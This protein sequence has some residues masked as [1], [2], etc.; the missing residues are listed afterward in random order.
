MIHRMRLVC[1]PEESAGS[2][3]GCG[4][5]GLPLAA[6]SED[7]G[8]GGSCAGTAVAPAD[9]SCSFAGGV[10]GLSCAHSREP[11]ATKMKAKTAASILGLIHSFKVTPKLFFSTQKP[12]P[13]TIPPTVASVWILARAFR[14]LWLTHFLSSLPCGFAPLATPFP[15]TPPLYGPTIGPSKEGYGPTR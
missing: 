6:S 3:L 13:S 12:Q 5:S 14:M 1:W 8:A 7:F 4:A 11:P 2:T 10:A 9:F 15:L